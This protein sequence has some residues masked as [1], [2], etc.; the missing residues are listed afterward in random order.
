MNS[1]AKTSQDGAVLSTPA[2]PDYFEHVNRL[3]AD[4]GV[5]VVGASLPG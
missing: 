5:E 2:D 1:N 4:E 3:F